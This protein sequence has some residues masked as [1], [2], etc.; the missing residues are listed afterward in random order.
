MS[1]IHEALR[2]VQANLQ[3]QPQPVTK[4][5]SVAGAPP[6]VPAPVP[7]QV[8]RSPRILILLAS[9]IIFAAAA[10]FIYTQYYSQIKIHVIVPAA[11]TAAQLL[12]QKTVVPVQHPVVDAPADALTVQGIMTNNGSTVALINGSIYEKGD[13][14][15][16]VKIIGITADAVTISRDG[17]EESIQIKH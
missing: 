15:N 9:G 4:P 14:I 1:I 7:V 2:K 17:K 11:H 16:G 10:Y 8:K 13:E 3:K 6:A 12:P 5:A